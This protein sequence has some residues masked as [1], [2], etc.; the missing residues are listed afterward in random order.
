MG[1]KVTLRTK[2]ITQNRQ[3]LYLDFFPAVT[4]I[5]TGKPT[6]RMFLKKYIYN[7]YVYETVETVDSKGNKKKCIQIARDKKGREL[8]AKLTL[9]QQKHNE[10]ARRIAESLRW[11]K[12][13]E[14]N[15]PEV[16]NNLEREQ[17]RLQKIGEM[18]FIEYY[19]KLADKRV[20][21]NRDLWLISI[22]Y[23]EAFTQR[24]IRFA[25]LNVK[26]CN[27]Y[28]D[29]LISADSM[30]RKDTKLAVNTSV[31]YF[32]KLKTTLKQ[33]YK[34]GLL[35]I[36]LNKQ[37][38]SIT[39]EENLREFLTL[40]ELNDLVNTPCKDPVMKKAALFSSLTGLRFSDIEK[41]N[42]EE[43]RYD[44]EQGYSIRFRQQ[45]TN[46]D[47][48]L[49]VSDQAIQLLGK[50]ELSKGL[51]FPDLEYSAYKNNILDEWIKAAGITKHI[52]FHSM[53]HTNATLLLSNGIDI[54][55]VSKMLG[56][57]SIKTTQVY[58]KV[59][60]QAKRQAA[61]KIKLNLN[62]H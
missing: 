59:L 20:G 4:D 19:K 6:R 62:S 2:P 51:V 14:L 50:T 47:E 15:K 11:Q 55:T 49:P 44:K 48:S 13:N 39:P 37:V 9:E 42:W 36:D 1:I 22:K 33:A 28:R 57:R 30:H 54:Y 21:S 43:I 10:H 52:R 29:Y 38:D 31:T 5:H 35:Q 60:D 34:D 24:P 40:E 16:Y 7:E 53:R 26:L 23:F 32:N 8:K 18:D 27:E 58:A 56:H 12:E 25:D 46:G 41:L 17:L 45:K 61:G 3:A